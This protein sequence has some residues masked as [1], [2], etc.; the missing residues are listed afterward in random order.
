M[1]AFERLGRDRNATRARR[2][3]QQDLRRGEALRVLGGH[4]KPERQHAHALFSRPIRS[5]AA[6]SPTARSF[7]RQGFR[8]APRILIFSFE[9]RVGRLSPRLMPS[10]GTI[11]RTAHGFVTFANAL[12]G[13]ELRR[14]TLGDG[15]L[16]EMAGLHQGPG[17]F[18]VKLR[19]K[20]LST[21]QV[22]AQLSGSSSVAPSKSCE[23]GM[24]FIC[25]SDMNG[26]RSALTKLGL[27]GGLSLSI[28]SGRSRPSLG[29]CG[30]SFG[31]I[32]SWFI[33]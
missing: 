33:V 1:T 19:G 5:T 31:C 10:S 14:A 27:T 20:V 11:E 13:A 3:A 18:A 15:R 16:K 28:H 7:A 2:G 8:V 17:T 12:R 29:I 21:R 23:P 24:T 22:T 30:S 32:G 9:M 25:A 4:G 26:S 6:R